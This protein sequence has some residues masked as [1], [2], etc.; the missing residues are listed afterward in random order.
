MDAERRRVSRL[1]IFEAVLWD[2]D[3]VLVDSERLVMDAFVDVIQK[4]GGLEDPAAF[5]KS[6]IGLNHAAIVSIYRATFPGDGEAEDI[7]N[8]VETLYKARLKTDLRLKPGVLASLQS[9]RELG[10]PQMVVTSTRSET[11]I[12]KLNLFSLMDYFNGL[13]GGDQVTQGKPHPE[14]YLSA[15]EQLK[16]APESTL[17]IEDSPNGV[18]AAIAAGCAVVHVPD[19]VETDPEWSDEIYDALDS[20]ESF[21]NWI[22]MQRFGDWV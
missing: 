19:L 7:F 10:L 21:P 14:P 3:G 6:T 4:K 12:H 15:C 13:I 8:Q 5:Y 17:V 11:A 2:M 18:R 1:A 16:V 20:L 9:I 22:T